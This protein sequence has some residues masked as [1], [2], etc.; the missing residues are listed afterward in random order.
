MYTK[1]LA[2]N[3]QV[4]PQRFCKNCKFVLEEK[5]ERLT[6]LILEKARDSVIG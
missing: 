3:V 4:L 2:R 1:L 6:C 5:A